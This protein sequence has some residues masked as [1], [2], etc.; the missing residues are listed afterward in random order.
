MAISEQLSNI[1]SSVVS[2]S[3][4]YERCTWSLRTALR[5]SGFDIL[6]SGVE[7]VAIKSDNRVIKI[8]PKGSRGFLHYYK[9]VIPACECAHTPKIYN[10]VEM[11]DT[12]IIEMEL[13]KELEEDLR[14]DT[15]LREE[16]FNTLYPDYKSLVYLIREEAMNQYES[17]DLHGGNVMLREDGTPVITDPYFWN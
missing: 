1:I 11:G 2:N 12:I 16:E 13:L 3:P 17:T 8:M 5:E 15:A 7:A 6:G 9:N 14:W 4:E 10:F